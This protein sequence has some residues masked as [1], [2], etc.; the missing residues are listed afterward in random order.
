MIKFEI[1]IQALLAMLHIAAK[2]DIRYYLNGIFIT[3]EYE[4]FVRY[5]ATNGHL[6]GVYR[7]KIM[8]EEKPAATNLI[9]NRDVLKSVKLQK[10]TNYGTLTIEDAVVEGEIKKPRKCTLEYAGMSIGFVE[11]DGKFPDY[12]RVLPVTASGETA[13]FNTALLMNFVKVGEVFLGKKK[14]VVPYVA[15]NGKETSA[16]MIPG[17]PDFIGAIMP[18]RIDSIGIPA[19]IRKEA[20]EISLAATRKW[21]ADLELKPEIYGDMITENKAKVQ[22]LEAVLTIANAEL[23]A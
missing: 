23:C 5:V 6:M 1:N 12:M 11:V 10:Y 4:G 17:L 3:T 16:V 15:H 7:D 13:Q 8:T 19:W 2:D 21:L 18:F 22:V 9:I 20:A 14:E